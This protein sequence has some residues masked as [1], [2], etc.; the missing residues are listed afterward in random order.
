MR[1][2]ARPIGP[3]NCL[4]ERILMNRKT[5]LCT[6]LGLSLLS[7]RSSAAIS[8]VTVYKDPTCGCC[9]KWAEHLRSNG[10]DVTV[11]ETKDLVGYRKKYGVPESLASCHTAVVEGYAIEGHVPA[12]EV[13]RV[14]KERPKA[15]G[16]AVPGMPL[17]SPGMDAAKAQ[18]Y[19]VLLFDEAGRSQVYQSYAAR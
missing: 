4:D 5:F 17:G 19:S 11:Q 2:A 10:F 1:A 6:V 12:R 15:K 3:V 8:R 13:Q 18:A 9:G 16:L 14:L 7:R